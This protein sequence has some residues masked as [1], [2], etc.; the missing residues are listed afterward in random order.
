MRQTTI[1]DQTYEF[2]SWPV[3]GEDIFKLAKQ[4]IESGHEF[5]RVIALAKGGLTFARSMVDYLNVKEVSSFQ[6]EFYTGIAETA[7]MPV[8]TQSLPVSVKNERI[9]I[10]DD[11]VD[12]G[13]TMKVATQ[14]L[15]YHGVKSL[16][17]ASLV[18]KPW[19][20]FD[21]EFTARETT[22][23]VIFPNEAR[24]TIQTLTGI[25]QKKGDSPD[26][27]KSQLLE[28]GFSEAEVALLANFN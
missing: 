22:A 24:E 27:I 12:L 26:K 28:V 19:S 16:T 4:I 23:W 8:I 13:E 9:L 20:K 10:F 15:Q 11:I 1:H 3:L 7:K 21:V 2:Y 6:I 17:T 18:K 5:D 14:Y 25:W